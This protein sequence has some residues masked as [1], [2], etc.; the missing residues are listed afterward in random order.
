MLTL[1]G[2]SRHI[3]NANLDQVKAG[4]TSKEVESVLGPP[5]RTEVP[6]EPESE[7]VKKRVLVT[8][9]YYDQDGHAVELT[10]VGD[11]LAT[12]G[13]KGNFDK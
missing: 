13:V 8:R 2:C 10:F 4:M 1:A 11:R 7:E 6:P 12:G 3:A 5:T 9:Y